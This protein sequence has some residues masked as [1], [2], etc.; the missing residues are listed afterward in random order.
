MKLFRKKEKGTNSVK[1]LLKKLKRHDTKVVAIAVIIALVLSGGLIY[2][3][4]P[5]VA[6]KTSEEFVESERQ[7]NQDTVDKLGEIGNYLNELDKV[8]T[9]NQ[10]SLNS[11]SEKT[12]TGEGKT[13]ITEKVTNLDNKL[14]EVHTSI[15]GTSSRIE[16]LKTIIEK[17][18]EDNKEQINK[19]FKEIT[20]EITL[21]KEQYDSANQQIKEIMDK[22]KKEIDSGNKELG[23]KVAQ[24]QK[25]LLNEL[26]SM[27]KNMESKS[28]QS[29][30]QFQKD[31]ETLSESVDKKFEAYQKAMD[32]NI[33]EVN[34][35]I[36]RNRDDVSGE[37]QK[38]K[39]DI[40]NEL[41]RNREDVRGE[42]QKNKDDINSELQRNRDD[43]NNGIQGVNKDIEEVNNNVSNNFNI[44]NK[45][46]GDGFGDLKTCIE[47]SKTELN[48]KLDSVFQRVSDG[49]NQLVSTLLTFGISVKKD[50]K[51]N[52][53]DEGIKTLGNMKLD[54]ERKI[55]VSEH[56]VTPSKIMAGQSVI[57]NDNEIL[58][59]ATGDATAGA[60]HILSG[61]TAYVNG[62][63]VVGSMPDHGAVQVT[64][65]DSN[66]SQTLAAGYYDSI[67]ISSELT[68]MYKSIRYTHH[69][70]SNETTDMTVVDESF[71]SG[72]AYGV[73]TS[74][75]AGGC[76]QTPIYGLCGG[77]GVATDVDYGGY[78]FDV[79]GDGKLD[80]NIFYV[81]SCT[82]C[83]GRIFANGIG[84][85]GRCDN[86][87]LLG[88]SASCGHVSGQIVAAEVTY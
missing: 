24:N 52:D 56:S 27:D 7:A 71:S 55:E 42:L 45:S 30:T 33:E 35:K 80:Q 46:V 68:G 21:V 72:E 81:G 88:Y 57:I 25:A 22:L 36:Q 53:I 5:I 9:S 69:V 48:N 87:R 59:T 34:N 54:A 3:S 49:K 10:E 58:G 73:E 28:S 44:M 26:T 8:V 17:G 18:D 11:I 16:N 20:S 13:E 67:T 51:F 60:E 63:I 64:L 15:S 41:Q 38:N 43:I 1:E 2:I 83:G 76:Y 29:L 4:T 14:K 82:S 12:D 37:I 66:K 19:E 70:H 75:T 61:K 78:Y 77:S 47:N 50:A 23:E 39:E 6:T 65:A 86:Q 31:I 85:T 62:A 32:T 40:N 74:P 79:D 84:E